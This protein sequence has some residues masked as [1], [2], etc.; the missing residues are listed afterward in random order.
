MNYDKT[1]KHSVIMICHIENYDVNQASSGY[2]L[3][4]KEGKN[5]RNETQIGDTSDEILTINNPGSGCQC[6]YLSTIESDDQFL[7]E[8]DGPRVKLSLLGVE[9]SLDIVVS[10]RPGSRVWLLGGG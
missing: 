6:E 9:N 7:V 3:P 2:K 4:Y 5:A 8:S 10:Y 1:G